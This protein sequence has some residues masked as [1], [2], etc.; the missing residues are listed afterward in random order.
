MNLNG[1]VYTSSDYK[2]AVSCNGVTV[3]IATL[4]SFDYAAKKESEYVHVI[5]SDEPVALKTNTST[6]PG[7]LTLQA[8]EL[9]I[10]LKALGFMYATQITNA[11]ISIVSFDGNVSKI[12]KSVVFD[13]HD[14]SV[15]AKD[16]HSLI[17]INFNSLSTVGM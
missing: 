2:L 8:G 7:K 11:T 13:S 10:L 16:K 6:Y 17:T 12:L 14:G 4:E 1:L 5:G 15:K 9:E 3:P